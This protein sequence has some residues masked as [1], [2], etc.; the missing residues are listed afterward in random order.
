MMPFDG[1]AALVLG[2]TDS[3]ASQRR[4]RRLVL[5]GAVMALASFIQLWQTARAADNPIKFGAIESL[6]GNGAYY[7]K[8]AMDA[9]RLGVKEINAKGGLL[10]RQIELLEE[11]D[12]DQ[13]ELSTTKVRKLVDEGADV[14]I[15]ASTSAAT[16]QNQRVALQTK[17]P[18]MTFNVSDA[19]TTRLDNPYFFQLGA[20]SSHQLTT[21]LEFSKERYKKVALVVDDSATGQAVAGPFRDGLKAAGIEV[22][23]E[24]TIP[25]GTTDVMPQIQRIRAANPD[26]VFMGATVLGEAALF[27]RTYRQAGLGYPIFGG[28]TLGIPTFLELAPNALDGVYFV[29]VF[30]PAKPKAAQFVAAFQKEYGRPPTFMSAQAVCYDIVNLY[31]D[32]IARA[33]STDKEAIRK[34]IAETTKFEAVSGAEGTYYSF[35]SGRR[36]GFPPDGIVVRVVEKNQYGPIVFPKK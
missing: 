12:Q 31:A 8:L 21:L 11:D 17:T 26:A 5:T 10:G 28:V 6:S 18:E 9:C 24:Q 20:L 15:A 22:V 30:D 7:S 3:R 25:T 29:D 19:L 35:A 33:G 27:F 1:R 2:A 36:W 32:A 34:A 23:V 14:L 13:P 16:M 4:T